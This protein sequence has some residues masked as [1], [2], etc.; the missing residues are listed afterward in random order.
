MLNERQL[1]KDLLPTLALK[2]YDEA[3]A[4]SPVLLQ[5]LHVKHKKTY[6]KVMQFSEFKPW[7]KF[8][9]TGEHVFVLCDR[10]N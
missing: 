3:V 6:V 10:C 2:V 1:Q 7:R 8:L 9:S 5:Y 4:D